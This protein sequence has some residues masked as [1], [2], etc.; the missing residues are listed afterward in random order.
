MNRDEDKFIVA[1]ISDRTPGTHYLYDSDGD[2]L[3]A[4]SPTRTR[5]W[6]RTSSR[7]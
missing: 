6:P 1:A 2:T 7:R 3:D 4:S 5:G